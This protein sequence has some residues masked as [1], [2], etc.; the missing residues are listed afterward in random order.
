MSDEST[1]SSLQP[2]T[3]ASVTQMAKSRKTHVSASLVSQHR[4]ESSSAGETKD[5]GDGTGC[6]EVPCS[7][8]CVRPGVLAMR[9]TSCSGPCC[10]RNGRYILGCRE[11]DEHVLFVESAKVAEAI[12]E[13]PGVAPAEG[14]KL[15]FRVGSYMVADFNGKYFLGE[16]VRMERQGSSAGKYLQLEAM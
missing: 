15:Q 5:D 7:S 14:A 8:V 12:V 13:Q 11:W 10:F 4:R 3:S 9:K 6:D 16:V 1:P 2:S